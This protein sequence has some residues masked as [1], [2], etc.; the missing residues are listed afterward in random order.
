MHIQSTLALNENL[1]HRPPTID[2]DE[3]VDRQE[4]REQTRLG[5][6]LKAAG[7]GSGRGPH[8]KLKHGHTGTKKNTTSANDATNHHVFTG[9]G[10]PTKSAA[11][12]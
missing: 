1:H 12:N 4:P 3:T 8:V 6:A 9:H 5:N 11:E 7:P 10:P 2:I